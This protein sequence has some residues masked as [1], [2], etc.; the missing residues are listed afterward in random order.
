MKI[1]TSELAGA[2]PDVASKLGPEVDV[3]EE[4]L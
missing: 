1:Q 2:A 4:L 3:P